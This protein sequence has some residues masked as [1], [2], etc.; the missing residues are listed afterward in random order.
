MKANLFD[1]TQP[2]VMGILN[3][4]PD[5]FFDGGKYT[6]S[7]AA[8]EQVEMMIQEGASI[9]DIGAIS[10]RPGAEFVDMETEKERILPILIEIRK[11]FP[12]TLISIDTFRSEIAR[13]VVSEGADIINDIAGG[14][15]D[16]NMLDTI[17]DL[18]IPYIMMHMKGTPQNMQNNPRYENVTEEINSY[19]HERIV[20]LNKLG[21]E[22]IILDP[23]FGFGKTI[24]HNYEIL[25]KFK[26][27]KFYGYPVLSGVSRKSMIYKV[28]N[29]TAQEALNGTSVINTISLMNGASILRVHDVKEAVECIK[30]YQK[31]TESVS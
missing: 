12:D 21:F 23:G 31:M 17:A 10:S 26:S 5:S 13:V 18:D 1:I 8:L 28:L 11:R 15:M 19:F 3:L 7:N 22:K 24:E 16:N 6:I 9:I 29:N 25:A 27:F 30:L 14:S 2:L 20:H 4:T